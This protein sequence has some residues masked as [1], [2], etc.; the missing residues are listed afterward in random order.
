MVAPSANNIFMAR[1]VG[2]MY[3]GKRTGTSAALRVA[4]RKKVKGKR[5]VPLNDRS[6][7]GC[8]AEVQEKYR[9]KWAR[10]WSISKHVCRTI[11]VR[12][13]RYRV[14]EVRQCILQWYITR[15]MDSIR[16]RSRY[17]STSRYG[18]RTFGSTRW[19]NE[20][21][22]ERRRGTPRTNLHHLQTRII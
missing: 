17:L 6:R 4:H 12:L 15:K 21:I 8:V 20:T 11:E 19:S 13:D 14:Y 10:A 16:Y 22:H 9:S 7:V 2:K 3:T 1:R 5:G 18:T